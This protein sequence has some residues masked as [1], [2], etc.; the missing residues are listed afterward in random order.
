MCSRLIFAPVFLA[1]TSVAVVAQ[2]H[3]NG[4][5]LTSPLS[6][7]S[8]YDEQFNTISAQLDD[9]VTL[10]NLPTLAWMKNTHDTTFTVDYRPEFEIFTRYSKLDA[11]NNAANLH[12]NHQIS[13]RLNVEAGDSFLSTMDP[14]RE[15]ENSLLL[16]PLG[17]FN[18]NS[19]YAS[20]GYRF[21]EKTKI[22]F[23]FDNAFTTATLPEPLAGRLDQ[24]SNAG[25]VT[26]NHTLTRHQKLSGGYSFL[27]VHPLDESVSGTPTSVNLGGVTYTY[28]NPSL[29][30]RLASGVA[31]GSQ[32]AFTGAAA[33]EKRFGGL[34]LAAGYQRYLS[35]FEDFVPIGVPEAPAGPFAQ[36]ITP[37]SV[38][39]VAS[40]RAWGQLSRRVGIK[41]QLQRAVSGVNAQDISVKS[42]IA[43]VRVDY[44]LTDRVTFFV[45]LE[46][47]EQNANEFSPFPDS[48]NRYFAGVEVFLSHSPQPENTAHRRGKAPQESIDVVPPEE[49]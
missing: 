44:K 28:E 32:S 12:V 37:S 8:G 18:Q 40:L 14:A 48:R 39:Q 46:R 43:Q 34:W 11:W 21:S 49:Q 36:G 41:G 24:V 35:F 7:S 20:L 19:A 45:R 2:D 1:L 10:V 4:F 30:L 31:V 29:V 42:L 27:Y 9:V 16:L 38:Y 26:L 23:R 6:V 15:L 22:T 5:Y 47:Y 33:V 13:G 3:P 25:T 17:R